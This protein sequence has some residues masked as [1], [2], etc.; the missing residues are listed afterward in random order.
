MLVIVFLGLLVVALSLD[1]E[2][3]KSLYDLIDKN[4][5]GVARL[6]DAFAA[7]SI[8][9]LNKDGLLTPVEFA[10][11]PHPGSPPLSIEEAFKFYDSRDNEKNDNVIDSGGVV[12]LFDGLDGNKN[13]KLTLQEMKE[14]YLPLF[15]GNQDGDSKEHA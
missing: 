5:D 11:G 7:Y 13:G 3:S 10:A 8:V 9:D 2:T 6:S 15:L 1:A 12:A 4:K 14:N